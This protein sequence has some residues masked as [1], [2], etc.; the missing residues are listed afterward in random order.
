MLGAGVSDE[1]GAL[2]YG[3]T[4]VGGA[5]I[6]GVLVVEAPTRR[7]ELNNLVAHLGLS[8]RRER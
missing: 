8:W 5:S 1:D 7:V 6:N 2:L 3:M 4:A